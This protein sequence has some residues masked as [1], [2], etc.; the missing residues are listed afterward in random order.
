MMIKNIL[1][2]VPMMTSC[3]KADSNN[4][5][6]ILQIKTNVMSLADT[7]AIKAKPPL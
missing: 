7:P 5:E 6:K 1:P 2:A 4:A 3:V